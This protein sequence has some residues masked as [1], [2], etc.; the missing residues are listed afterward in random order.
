[1]RRPI[2]VLQYP[3]PRRGRT[4]AVAA[5]RNPRALHVFKGIVLQETEQTCFEGDGDEVV[6]LL[7]KMEMDRLETV[8][9]ALIPPRGG[10]E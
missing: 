9:D 6:T 2:L 3:D 1:M 7:D 10:R 5:T 8:L 4:V